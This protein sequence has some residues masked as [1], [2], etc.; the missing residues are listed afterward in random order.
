VLLVL[1][2]AGI[3]SRPATLLAQ[4]GAGHT[5]RWWHGAV[6]AGGLSVLMLLDRPIQRFAGHNS[7]TGADNVAAIARH[8]GQPEVYAAVPIG[9]AAVGLATGN[10]RILRTARVVGSSVL[11]AGATV[12]SSKFAF[13]RPRPDASQDADG[14]VPFSGQASMPSGHTAAA[15]ALATSLSDEIHNPLATVGLYGL[16]TA[17]GWSRINDNRHWFTDVT[18]GALV[19]ITSAKLM[20]GKWRIFG[21]RAPSVTAS[22]AGGLALGWK[23][24]F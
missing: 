4:D 18:A 7:G 3:I 20:S 13:G 1:S 11:L 9:I 17:T 8:M 2:L 23:G 16:A 14:F 10:S 15:F 22:P 24:E 6:A 5:I 12:G 19:G 21:L